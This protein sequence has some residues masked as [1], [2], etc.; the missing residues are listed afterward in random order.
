[1][2]DKLLNELKRLENFELTVPIN[3]DEDGYF[4]RECPDKECLFQ[5]KVYDDDWKNKFKEEAA[6]CPMCGR[7]STSDRFNTTAQVENA[8][9]QGMEYFQ[10][11]IDKALVDDT[12]DFNRKQPKG[13]FISMSIKVTGAKPEKIILP[14]PAREKFERKLQCEKCNSRYAVIGSAFFC[15]CCGHN[16][17]E[18][19]FDN[20]M[21]T[22]ESSIKSI[23]TIKGALSKVSKDTAETTCRSL[24]E[25]GLLDCVVSFQRYCDVVYKRQPNAKSKVPFNAFQKIAIGDGLWKELLSESY[26]DWL[27]KKQ[28]DRMNILFQRRHLLQHTEGIVDQMYIDNTS[29]P[30]YTPGQRIVVN[31]NDALELVGYIKKIIATIK[32]KTV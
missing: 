10:G 2:F 1:M 17:I 27:T 9:K 18:K 4:D 6:F 24:V 16:S 31:E 28:F 19:T 8:T 29:D 15:P 7:Q 21:E 5:F 14:I 12:S 26:S 3:V 22:I 30:K 13:G 23:D 11:R 32:K 25:K 20:S